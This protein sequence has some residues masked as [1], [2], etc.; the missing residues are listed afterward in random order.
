MIYSNYNYY[1]YTAAAS[2]T[3]FVIG[4]ITGAVVCI[5][6]L[7]F[8]HLIKKKRV[9]SHKVKCDNPTNPVVYDEIKLDKKDTSSSI[10]LQGNSAYG[11]L[12]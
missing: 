11:Q 10:K 4:N 9:H 3:S 1:F 2:V 7:L 5:C 12:N 8:F 6:I